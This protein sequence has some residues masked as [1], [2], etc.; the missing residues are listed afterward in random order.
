LAKALSPD[1]EE[2]QRDTLTSRRFAGGSLKIVAAKAPRNLRRHTARILLCD[3]VDAMEVGPE[4]NPIRLA[5]RRT[6]TFANRK[7][8]CGSTPIFADTSHVLRAYGESDGR[9]FECRCPS[10]GRSPKLCGRIS[11]GPTEI[12]AL[13]RLNVRIARIGSPSGIRLRWS[14]PGAG[15]RNGQ[16]FRAMPDLN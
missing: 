5:E 7:I 4:G 2:G 11:F 3:E 9:V 14:G 1:R 13:R 8:V 15:G 16:T 10:C 12:R 6:L